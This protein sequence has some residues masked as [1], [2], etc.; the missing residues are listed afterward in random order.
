MA[1]FDGA[2]ASR[3]LDG[4][5]DEITPLVDRSHLHPG[6]GQS[7]R[8]SIDT[9]SSILTSRL[10]R[11]EL[12]LADTAVGERLPY[13]AYQTIDWLHDLI[14]DAF[15]YRTIKSQKGVR[16]AFHSAY[17]DYQGWLAAALVG[18]LTAFV[19][20]FVD[21][22]ESS[23]G[24]LKFGY[25]KRNPI[26]GKEACCFPRETCSEWH[27][28]SDSY[29]TSF[30][31]YA[32]VA[33]ALAM[34]AGLVTKLT[35]TEIP[36][37]ATHE[38]H[39]SSGHA[40]DPNAPNRVIFMAAGSGIPEIKLLLSGYEF[41]NLLS[42]KV[43]VVKAVGAA[44]AV[45]SG[46]CLGKEGPFVHISTS[47]GYVVAR[48]FP[49]F[50]D[51]G[52]KMREMLSIACSSAL[53]VAFGSPV[54]GVLFVYEEM[55]SQFPR[56]VLW[57]AFLCSLI[58]AIMLKALDPTRTG[59]LVLFET[60][61]GV[62]YKPHNY[63]FFVMLGICGGLFGAAFCKGSQMWTKRM[64][65]FINRHPLVELSGIVLV[66]AALQY[67]NP[68]TREP[69]LLMIRNLLRDCDTKGV[70]GNAKMDGW[71]CEQ[72]RQVDKTGYYAWL[73]YGT[74]VKIVLTIVTV[75]SRIP[76][77]LIVPALGAGAISGRLLGQ[78][79]SDTSPAIFAMVG[80]AAFLA[81]VSRMTVSLTVIMLELTGEVEYIPPF[82]IAILTAKVVVDALHEEGVNDHTVLG[83]FLEHEHASKIA[84]RHGGLVEDLIPPSHHMADMTFHVGPEYRVLKQALS[85]KL[86]RMKR[87]GLRDAAL[88]LVDDREQLH[89]IISEA[90][91]D[92]AV[93][94]EGFL[95]DTEPFD[96]LTGPLAPFVD[97]SPLTL[98]ATAPLEMVVEM[99]Y[100]LGLRHVVIVEEG[101]S[102]VLG[103]VLKQQLVL[104]LE[105]LR[106]L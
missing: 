54:G 51:N 58:A 81:G 92:F 36:A 1:D 91:L 61:Y 66:T 23:F 25:C 35:R 75:G 2:S 83:E 48:L 24:D 30:A 60:N 93:N 100:Q 64:K 62:I 52:R 55:S 41:P 9:V 47:A 49:Q 101:S 31:I 13:N 70:S 45:A 4:A 18:I 43:L 19:A 89:G 84:R 97:R 50:R 22:A 76:S 17:E 88:V 79:V 53:A 33:W 34:G 10:S 86:Q 69:A 103:V 29:E 7:R 27:P 38:A 8:R 32:A 65:P 72:E 5:A 12:A 14:K 37:F 44:L 71:I 77:G 39:D 78:I 3:R 28:W 80:A 98:N 56:K 105:H 16:G 87:H 15:R 67:P 6:Y 63:V 42:F 40:V 57:K 82:M 68:I 106:E 95:S 90:E 21:Y 74:I 20:F 46:L 59:R 73:I 26:Y 11:D 94:E 96:V 102:R 99:F 104:Y 85:H